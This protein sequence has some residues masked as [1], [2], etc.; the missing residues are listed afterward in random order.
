MFKCNDIYIKMVFVKFFLLDS[1]GLWFKKFY[2]VW[3]FL[4]YWNYKVNFVFRKLFLSDYFFF[5]NL[6]LIK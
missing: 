6:L 1:I 5:D 4:M 2:K 3:Y